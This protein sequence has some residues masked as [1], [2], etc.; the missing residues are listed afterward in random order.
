MPDR[1][2]LLID[3]GTCSTRDPVYLPA[4]GA[5]HHASFGLSYDDLIVDSPLPFH[6][7]LS[8]VKE[9]RIYQCGIDLAKM[10][11]NHPEWTR[12]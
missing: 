9:L 8:Q 2:V 3:N 4:D 10:L 12:N 5:W 6:S 1:L 11:S 7:A